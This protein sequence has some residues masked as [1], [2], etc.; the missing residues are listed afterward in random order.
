[1]LLANQ[2]FVPEKPKLVQYFFERTATTAST[3]ALYPGWQN[4]QGTALELAAVLVPA[5]K[6]TRIRIRHAQSAS[7][8]VVVTYEL[9]TAATP[10]AGLVGTGLTVSL[11]ANAVGEDTLDVDVDLPNGSRIAFVQLAH[12]GGVNL[13]TSSIGSVEMQ[14]AA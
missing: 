4:A 1:M 7:D 3:L 14:E 8:P 12:G 2:A 13:T 9:Y 10:G 11:P 6:I 5:V